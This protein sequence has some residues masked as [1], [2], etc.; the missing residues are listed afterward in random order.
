MLTTSSSVYA[1]KLSVGLDQLQGLSH[2]SCDLCILDRQ[3]R[4]PRFGKYPE[5][6]NSFIA[7]FL[8]FT[9]WLQITLTFLQHIHK[10]KPFYSTFTTCYACCIQQ[11]QLFSGQIMLGCHTARKRIL[12]IYFLLLLLFLSSLVCYSFFCFFYD[13]ECIL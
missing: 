5:G 12:L 6:E 13:N 1:E 10:F 3:S 11:F 7:Q 9:F 8:S 4:L 2:T